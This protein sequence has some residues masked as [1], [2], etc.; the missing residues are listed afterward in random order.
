[1][2]R[3]LLNRLPVRRD[4]ALLANG[5]DRTARL[6]W[7][8]DRRGDPR[9]DEW[10]A[11]AALFEEHGNG[12]LALAPS[13]ARRCRPAPL[14]ARL[15]GLLRWRHSAN[16]A[17]ALRLSRVVEA[18]AGDAA[19]ISVAG[20]W[21]HWHRQRRVISGL[22]LGNTV[23]VLDPY[24]PQRVAATLDGLG[25]EPRGPVW[26]PRPPHA[27]WHDHGLL[28]LGPGQVSRFPDDALWSADARPGLIEGP[29]ALLLQLRALTAP[30][31]LLLTAQLL[32]QLV[33]TLRSPATAQDMLALARRC[34]C[35]HRLNSLLALLQRLSGDRTVVQRLQGAQG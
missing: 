30:R 31:P 20:D 35:Q 10:L 21:V 1:M 28:V 3:R 13:L 22:H 33:E 6:A 16:S 5:F 11:D 8:L 18:L 34:R 29:L 15:A 24:D 26:R 17:H 23:L 14:P 7:G 32:D 2:I 27:G 4:R 25:W 9:L 12:V 19:R